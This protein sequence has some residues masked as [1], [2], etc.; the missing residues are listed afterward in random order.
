[1]ATIIKVDGTTETLDLTDEATRL[2]KL[3]EAV[4]GYI[5]A[6]GHTPGGDII[7]ANEDGRAMELDL[8]ETA[9]VICG[10]PIVGDVVITSQEENE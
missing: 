6:V 2:D 9:M 10:R 7:F 3:Q 1:M 8:N 4:G 5:E